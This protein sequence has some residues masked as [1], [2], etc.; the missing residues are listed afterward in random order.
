MSD[1][2]FAELDVHLVVLGQVL[3]DRDSHLRDILLDHWAQT[4]SHRVLWQLVLLVEF[5]L[6]LTARAEGKLALNKLLG[7][8]VPVVVL[9][10]GEGCR[11]DGARRVD[12]LP[13]VCQI[14]TS[15]DLLDQGRRQSLISDALVNA[16]EVYLRHLDLV[17]VDRHVHGDGTDEA[18]EVL[19]AHDTDDPVLIVARG[20]KSPPQELDGVIE[21]EF[22]LSVLNVVVRQK[23]VY[24]VGL[25]VIH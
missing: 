23:I 21:A 14:N 7:V 2:F 5:G 18:D 3:I 25:I 17:L 20:A 24:L 15:C 16:Q 19:V 11:Q 8:Q 13:L 12:G 9:R 4:L 6:V 1:L 22:T 10:N